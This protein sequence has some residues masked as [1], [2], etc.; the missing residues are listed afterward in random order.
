MAQAQ[1]KEEIIFTKTQKEVLYG[2][3]LGDGSLIKH[4]NGINAQFTYLSKSKQHVSFVAE[5]FKEYWSGEGIK[6][7]SY[8]DKRTNKK[9]HHSQVK[10]YTNPGF[11][12]EYYH[13]Y[14]NGKKHLPEDLTLTP[15]TCLIWYIGDGGICHNTRSENIK[16]STQCFLKEEQE[17][18]LIPQLSDFEATLMKADLGSNGEQQYYIYIPHRKEKAF[19]DY[20]GECPFEDY[21]YKWEVT[22]YINAIPKNYTNKEKEFDEKVQK[23]EEV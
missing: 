18:I 20:I 6:D 21:K 13:W 19:L 5:Y 11:T 15:L 17:K 3:L 23:L 12:K 4:K 10:T 7:T 14:I 1:L 22:E 16:L 8:I 9:Y 2:A